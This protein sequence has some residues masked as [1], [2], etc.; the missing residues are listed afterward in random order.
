M[1][2]CV[3]LTKAQSGARLAVEP[4]VIDVFLVGG[5]CCW[6][7]EFLLIGGEE[8]C[9]HAGDVRDNLVLC[10]YRGMC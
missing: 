9:E 1:E 4:G 8:G 6:F 2:F 10:I 3:S 7:A 5:Y